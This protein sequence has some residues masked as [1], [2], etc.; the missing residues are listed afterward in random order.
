MA[1]A[2]SLLSQIDAAI[3]SLL[4]GGAESYSIGNRT[5]TK[6]DLGELFE[7]RNI[8]QTQVERESGGGLRLAKFQRRSR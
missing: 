8:L 6:L 5:V 1:T 2:A 7:Q 4:T 3:E